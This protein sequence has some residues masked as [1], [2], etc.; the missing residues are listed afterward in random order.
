M[1]RVTAENHRAEEVHHRARE[2]PH[3]VCSSSREED[4]RRNSSPAKLFRSLLEHFHFQ[5]D[6]A[7]AV[8]EKRAL[9]SAAKTVV[10]SAIDDLLNNSAFQTWGASMGHWVG[11]SS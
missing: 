9:G 7:L 2:Q 6:G 1:G 8:G 3:H 11:S 4:P 5:L 10:M